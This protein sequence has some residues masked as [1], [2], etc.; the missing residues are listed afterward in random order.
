MHR[1]CLAAAI[2]LTACNGHPIEPLEGVVTATHRQI[3]TLPAKT[4]LDFLFVVDSSSS[5]CQ[6]Q[7]N[8]GRNFSAFAALFDDLGDAA[9]YRIAVTSMDMQDAD[10]RG[11]FLASPADPSPQPTCNF[12]VPNTAD[13][14]ADLPPILRS[15][16]DGNI[17]DAA[18]L[19]RKFR[20]LATLGTT[21]NGF[22]MGLE[23]MRQALDCRGPNAARFGECCTP[24]GEYDPTCTPSVEPDFLR[25]D[26]MLVV[27]F[28]TDEN[29]CSDP[30]AN[31]GRSQQAICK[32]GPGDGDGDGVP[33]GYR[34]PRLCG[35]DPATCFRQEC[36]DLDAAACQQAR[37]VVDKRANT[38]CEW[39]RDI[40]TPVGDYQRF[41]TGLKPHPERSIVVA[42][43]VG[44]RAYTTDTAEVITWQPGAV[45]EGCDPETADDATRLSAT[46]CPGGRC[47]GPVELSCTSANGEAFA[48]RR[49]LDLA[50]RFGINGVG[51]PEGM[52]GDDGE[53]LSICTGDFARPLGVVKERVRG[54]VASYCLDKRPA[55]VDGACTADSPRAIAVRQR[56]LRDAAQGGVC[57]TV[58]DRVLGADEFTLV[59]DAAECA[60][61]AMVALTRIPQGGSEIVIDYRTTVSD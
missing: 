37:C 9:D 26:A 47:T 19:E 3:V 24:E 48:G 60:S 15:G 12:E 4:K 17:A 21:G 28:I 14:P 16:R 25:P 31:P 52:E 8:L 18:A 10:H 61:G 42:T 29:D 49:Y 27:V 1:I 44:E 35:A 32:Y 6:E 53:C 22:E 13:C 41:L 23:S 11:R 36:G 50:E 54:V 40:L 2:A 57:E 56:C 7:D 34:D 43:I 59:L 55:C 20:C 58:E 46:C 45:A 33:D 39:Q 38:N 30:N 51:C 5:M